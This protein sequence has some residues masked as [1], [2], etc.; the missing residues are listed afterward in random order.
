MIVFEE[1]MA[2]SIDGGWEAT[3]DISMLLITTLPTASDATPALA[4]Y[5][6]VTAGGNYSTGGVSLGTLGSIIT[7]AAGVV[8]ADSATNPSW[9]TNGSNPTNAV[10]ALIVN[11]TQSNQAW[12]FINLNGGSAVNMSTTDLTVTLHANGLFQITKA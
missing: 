3:D 9:A 10:A 6:E 2:Y 7:E 5:T 11:T 4:D 1:A 8:T 12:G